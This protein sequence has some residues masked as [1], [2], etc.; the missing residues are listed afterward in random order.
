MMKA[1]FQDGT[2]AETVRQRSHGGLTAELFSDLASAEPV[3][4]A[5]ETNPSVLATPYQRFDWIAAFVEARIDAS[6]G[7]ANAFRVIVVRDAIGRARMLLPLLVSSE[8]G[9]RVARTIGGKHA[10]FQMPLFASRDAATV[11]PDELLAVLSAA[12]REIGIDAYVFDHQPRF[13]EGCPNPLSARGRPC[14]SDAYGFMLGLDAETTAKR[15]FSNDTRKKLRAKERK[16]VE[17][18]GPIEH[19]VARTPEA[20]TAVLDAFYTQKSARLVAMGLPNPY[21]EPAIRHFLKAAAA[22]RDGAE[23]GAAMEVHAL[24]ATNTNRVLATFGGAV[25]HNRFS[26]MWT[27]FDDDP[28]LR[29]FSPGDVLLHRLIA[30]QANAGRRAFDLGVGE[31]QYKDRICDET[32]E[33]VTTVLPLTMVGQAYTVAAVALGRLKHRIK[34]SPRLWAIAQRLRGAKTA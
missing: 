2:G 32:I 28:A 5:L 22:Y 17:T 7:E 14:P 21:A 29:R 12:G 11:D 24:M 4:R 15:I 6:P 18:C 26:G 33:L 31:A 23:P 13:W 1:A 8:R 3:W 9:V 34:R 25:D 16:L 27:S 10:N 19:C 30:D 20:I